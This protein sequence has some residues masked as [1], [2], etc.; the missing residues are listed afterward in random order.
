MVWIS[1]QVACPRPE[2]VG[3][4]ATRNIM[5]MVTRSLRGHLSVCPPGTGLLEGE[6]NSQSLGVSYNSQHSGDQWFWRQVLH[7]RAL[8][9]TWKLW[10]C[11][12]ATQEVVL[13]VLGISGSGCYLRTDDIFPVWIHGPGPHGVGGGSQELVS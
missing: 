9:G 13:S 6:L 10:V 8:S 5:P 11:N 1:E 12:V 4:P 2:W 7:P 3:Q